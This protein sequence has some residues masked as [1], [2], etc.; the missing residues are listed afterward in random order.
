MQIVERGRER[1]TCAPG[2]AGL[3]HSPWQGVIEN[4]TI[5]IVSGISQQHSE[6][7]LMV[8]ERCCEKKM[9]DLSVCF[10]SVWLVWLQIEWKELLVFASRQEAALACGPP[11]PERASF[12]W[13]ARVRAPR[14][15]AC[16][17]LPPESLAGSLAN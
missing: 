3:L 8:R 15:N 7:M 4:Q 2:R 11:P 10:G 6:I 9:V 5:M 1:E 16:A 13:P 17:S 12:Q 14:A